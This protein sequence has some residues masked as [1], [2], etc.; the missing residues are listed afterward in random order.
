MADIVIHQIENKTK[1][2]VLI[3]I[4]IMSLVTLLGEKIFQNEPIPVELF[5][6]LGLLFI[7]YIALVVMTYVRFYI[8]KMIFLKEQELVAITT[9]RT[10]EKEI[11]KLGLMKDIKLLEVSVG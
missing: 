4:A 10:L 11:T 8:E 9:G 1:V 2:E 3:G 7:A 6:G 5:W